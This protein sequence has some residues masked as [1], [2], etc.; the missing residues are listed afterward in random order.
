MWQFVRP[1][2]LVLNISFYH[3]SEK[4]E[5]GGSV[6]KLGNSTIS[7]S[8]RILSVVM[9]DSQ[10]RPLITKNAKCALFGNNTRDI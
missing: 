5:G 4:S 9:H 8:L 1:I 7:A 3:T 2:N 10:L 6:S